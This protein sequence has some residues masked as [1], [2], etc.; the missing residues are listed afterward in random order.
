MKVGAGMAERKRQAQKPDP[1][2]V[3]W[4]YLLDVER[5]ERRERVLA[6]LR[7]P[8]RAGAQQIVRDLSAL[9]VDTLVRAGFGVFYQRHEEIDASSSGRTA[10]WEKHRQE[11]EKKAAEETEL[12]G[13]EISALV[14][15][16]RAAVRQVLL[17]AS[18]WWVT[19]RRT[20][21]GGDIDLLLERCADQVAAVLVFKNLPPP[22]RMKTQLWWDLLCTRVA[23]RVILPR[24]GG[25]ES[26]D[27]VRTLITAMLEASMK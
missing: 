20:G 1:K 13:K 8:N 7:Q 22:A 18:R 15:E 5:T 21:T 2:P 9:A 12:L 3:E 25:P 24:L 10:Q 27:R 14:R 17:D 26:E 16:D 6:W 19:A 11:I 4:R 23:R